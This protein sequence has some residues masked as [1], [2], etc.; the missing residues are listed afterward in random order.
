MSTPF[1]YIVQGDNIIVVI[2][3]ITHTINRNTHLSA[4]DKIVTA[5]KSNDWDSVE[6]LVD[7]EKSVKS[8]GGG[9]L[10][11]V[12]GKIHFQ[13]RVMNKALSKRL[14]AMIRDDFPFEYLVKF[15]ENIMMNPSCRAVNELYGFLEFNDLPITPDGYFLA[16]KRVREDYTDCYTGTFDNRVGVTNNMPRNS[17]DD[18]CRKTCSEGLHFASLGYVSGFSRKDTN[19]VMILKIH[20]KDVVSIPIDYNNQKGRCCEYTV[21]GEHNVRAANNEQEAFDKPVVSM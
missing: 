21:V 14:T 4:Y 15:M 18:D 16:Y 20:P 17:V 10:S 6:R 1:P 8:Y 13:G 19:H 3:N 11:I 2:D 9:K 7:I 12:D 5:I